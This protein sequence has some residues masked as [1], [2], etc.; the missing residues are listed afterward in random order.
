MAKQ[1]TFLTTIKSFIFSFIEESDRGCVIA[2]GALVDDMLRDLLGTHLIRLSGQTK[3]VDGLLDPNANGML[4]KF[5]SRVKITTALGLVD[6]KYNA[7]LKAIGKVRNEFTHK[8][9]LQK[10]NNDT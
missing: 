9:H 7:S 1:T 6:Y 2:I 5:S 4:A 8:L 3:F 10:M